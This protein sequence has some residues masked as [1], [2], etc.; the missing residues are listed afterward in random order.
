MQQRADSSQYADVGAVC[1]T[2]EPAEEAD[3]HTGEQ[4]CYHPFHKEGQNEAIGLLHTFKAGFHAFTQSTNTHMT[5]TPDWSLL[6]HSNEK[7][8]TSPTRAVLVG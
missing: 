6:W 5:Q 7:K 3:Q 1:L 4:G 8:K 2:S